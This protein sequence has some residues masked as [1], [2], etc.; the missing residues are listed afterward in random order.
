MRL[1]GSEE[2]SSGTFNS[3]RC[4][5]C[6]AECREQAVCTL[7]YGLSNSSLQ[8][9][10]ERKLWRIAAEESKVSMALQVLLVAIAVLVF[11]L[12]TLRRQQ[13]AATREAPMVEMAGR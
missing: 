5:S 6:V 13:R 2:C 4:G 11:L 9:C 1:R 7:L 12:L 8:R 10:V 3:V